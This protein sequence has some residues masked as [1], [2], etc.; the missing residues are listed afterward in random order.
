MTGQLA[1]TGRSFIAL[2]AG[3]YGAMAISLMTNALL[4]H[5]LGAE[6]FGHLALLL[7]ASQVLLLVAVNWSHAGFVRFGAVEFASHGAVT[8]ALWARVGLVWPIAVL[9][10]VVM[11]VARQPLAAYLVI[12]PA[13]V[14]LLLVHFVAVCAL[15]LV[16]AVFQARD[17][18][19][20][21]GACLFLDKTG[22]LFCVVAL[23]A[24]WTGNPLAALGCYAA[25]SL[26][27]AAWGLSVVGGRA[28]R[29]RWP[30]REAYRQMALFSTPLLLTS[31]AGFFSTNWFDL[32]ILKQYVSLSDIGMYS[33][34][35]QLAG[36]VQQITVIF[37]TLLLPRVSMMVGQGQNARVMALMER[38]LPYWLLATSV[39]FTLVVVGAR[40]GLPL[41]FGKSFSGAAP[42]LALLMVASCALAFYNAWTPLVTAYGSTWT[43]TGVSFVSMAINVVLDLVLIPRFGISGSAVAT[44]MAYAASMLLVLI[45]MQRRSGD[46][47][48]RLGWLGTPPLVACACFLL[49]DGFWFYPAALGMLAINVC[50]LVAAFQLFRA[51]DAAF[52][53]GL[54]LKL[55]FGL[56]AGTPTGGSA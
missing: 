22:M 8:E 41:V 39:L 16:G 50:A 43:L 40:V 27:V 7:M 54:N 51:D 45:F 20:R 2:G 17:Q 38:L 11:I 31:W 1:K 3:N 32:V 10:A 48:L 44:V 13:A 24:A 37:S 55:P 33:L 52:L 49:F 56:G 12:P 9:G 42:A 34:A 4:A 14:W 25:S 28:L 21:Y 35:T 6:Q 18:M 46:R 26:A 15:S 5:R 30:A 36:V 47:I 19:A 29:P 23:P 53:R